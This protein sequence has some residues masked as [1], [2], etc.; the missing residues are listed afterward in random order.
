MFAGCVTCV[1]VSAYKKAPVK[2]I[3]F[4]DD[5]CVRYQYEEDD[6]SEPGNPDDKDCEY[7]P[8]DEDTDEDSIVSPPHA[9][10]GDELNP[11]KADDGTVSSHGLKP[12]FSQLDGD[13]SDDESY[14]PTLTLPKLEGDDYSDDEVS[15]GPPPLIARNDSDD[16][17]ASDSNHH[18]APCLLWHDKD[19]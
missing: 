8:A 6:E 4:K 10:Y 15:R 13:S 17:S 9:A 14:M 19:Q 11:G 18:A 3:Y 5:G 7:P 2:M 16:E 1:D 12:K